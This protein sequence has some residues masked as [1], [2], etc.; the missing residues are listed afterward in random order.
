[1]KLTKQQIGI[2]IVALVMFGIIIGIVV[3][4][5]SREIKETLTRLNPTN[6]IESKGINMNIEHKSGYNQSVRGYRNNNPLNLRISSNKWKGKVNASQNTDGAFEQ[7]ETMAYGFRAALKN[8]QTYINKYGC[9][10]IATIVNKWAPA[11]DGNNPTNYANTVASRTGISKT[12]G[13]SASDKE[14]MCRIAAAMAYVENGSAPLME[15]VYAG[16]NMI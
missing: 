8:L 1:M 3:Y 10:A 11:S 4:I 13:I 2:S 7:F 6:A 9:S 16:W 5:L 14:Q 15:D 12:E